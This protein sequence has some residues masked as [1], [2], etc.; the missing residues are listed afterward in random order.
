MFILCRCWL[1]TTYVLFVYCLHLLFTLI[2]LP[3]LNLFFIY[4]VLP[5]FYFISFCSFLFVLSL[6]LLFFFCLLLTN[7]PTYLTL[8]FWVVSEKSIS[9]VGVNL[10]ELS[11]YYVFY[12]TFQTIHIFHYSFLAVSSHRVSIS[13]I[14][15]PANE[16]WWEVNINI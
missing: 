15:C 9:L 11:F 10:L 8:L 2:I 16:M 4:I 14:K 6:L 3:C 13:V 7:N 1:F 12:F 5:Y